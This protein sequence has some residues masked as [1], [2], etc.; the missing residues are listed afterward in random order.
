MGLEGTVTHDA[1]YERA[2]EYMQVCHK[3]WQSWEPDA[4]VGDKTS[5]VYVDPSKV[6][7][8]NHKGKWFSCPASRRLR[9]RPRVTRSFFR[10]AP[11]ALDA[12]SA[13][14]TPRP[15]SGCN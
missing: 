10:L 12:I 8:I 13:P 15:R 1:R 11:Q 3:L 6:H 4:V 9:L 14:S 5:G 2:D 7:P